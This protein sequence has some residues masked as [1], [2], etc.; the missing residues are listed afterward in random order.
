[1]RGGIPD[2]EESLKILELTNTRKHSRIKKE[3]EFK[4]PKKNIKLEE[5]NYKYSSSDEFTLKNINLSIPIGS[6]IAFVGKTGSGKTTVANQILCLLSP[7][8]GKILL[9]DKELKKS[10]IGVWQSSCSYV[11]QSIN[12]LNS[13]FISNVAYGLD[14]KKVNESK[15]WQCLEAGQLSDLVKNLPDRLKTKIGDNGIRLSGGQRQRIAI[16]RAFYRDTKLLILDEA[17]SALDNKTEANIIDALFSI[18]KKLTIII[19]AHR[20]STI[21]ECDCIYEFEK[22]EIK[23]KGKF[24]ELKV[25]SKSFEEKI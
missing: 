4:F 23:A 5:I 19:I 12:L 13:D 20:L 25:N 14:P 21:K 18:N 22:G 9:D 10:Q 16:A 17:T 3:K 6:K 2:L 1:M 24:E 8:S 15:I 11:P 7:T